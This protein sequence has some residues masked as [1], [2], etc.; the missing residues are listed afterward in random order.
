MC[1]VARR[2][3]FVMDDVNINV[4]LI[5]GIIVILPP[6]MLKDATTMS[7]VKLLKILRFCPLSDRFGYT[8][9]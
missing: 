2:K 7:H 8:V 4:L 1:A 5:D 9:Q 6:P 3:L